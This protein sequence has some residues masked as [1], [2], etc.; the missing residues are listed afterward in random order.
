MKTLHFDTWQEFREFVDSDQQ[1]FPVYWRGQRDPDWPLASRFE[2]VILSWVPGEI[3]IRPYGKYR[4]DGMRLDGN[5]YKQF[6]DSYLYRFKRAASGLRGPNP[7]SLSDEQWWA[8]GRNYGL[9]TPLLD[10]TEKPYIAAFFALSERKE[11]I[12]TGN[13]KGVAIY[14]L[15]HN[16]QLEGDGLRVVKPIVDELG[17]LQ[18]QRGVFTWLN[19]ENYFELQDF[20]DKN[21]RGDLLVKITLSLHVVED[22]LSD[23]DK[24][25]IDHRLLFPDLTGAA[26][27]ANI[28]PVSPLRIQEYYQNG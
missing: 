6:R 5:F 21:G 23:L 3:Q 20:M 15:F 16:Q 19:S 8:L 22:G 24:H 4:F 13:D 10:W 14:Q 1:E 26:L 28:P 12:W 7:S 9:I 2:R 25:G 18:S 11:H 17:R 27:A